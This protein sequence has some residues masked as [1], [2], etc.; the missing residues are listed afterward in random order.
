MPFRTP[1]FNTLFVLGSCTWGKKSEKDTVLLPPALHIIA[2][3]ALSGYLG[4]SFISKGWQPQRS[5]LLGKL[6]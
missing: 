3:C 4:H 2:N 1:R 6:F 5:H